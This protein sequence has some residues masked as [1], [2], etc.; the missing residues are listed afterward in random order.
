MSPKELRSRR[1]ALGL[2]LPRLASE[3]G[4]TTPEL[5]QMENGQL[6]LPRGG[7][8]EAALAQLEARTHAERWR[9]CLVVEDESAVRELFVR[10]LRAEGLTVDEAADGLEA[11]DA[12]ATRDYRLLLLDLRLPK[13]SGAEVLARV[14]RKT[15]APANVVIISATGSGD[16]R[17][18]AQ[19]KN[20]NAILRKNFA[21]TNADLVFPAL[22][23]LA[24][25]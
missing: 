14:S 7:T 2:P 20:V 24:R 18:V 22:A 11:L 1:L 21:I 16:V 9:D 3:L 12:T 4:L 25:A 13:L 10:R 15:A 23:A 17:A 6:A 19:N 5:Q 8:L